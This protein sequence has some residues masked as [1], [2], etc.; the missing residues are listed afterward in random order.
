VPRYL[1]EAVAVTISRKN[2]CRYCVDAHSIML[3][4]GGN[5]ALAQAASHFP[6]PIGDDRARAVVDW[7]AA[8]YSPSAA[9]LRAPPF[10]PAETPE[11]IGTAVF[12]H[13]INR[14]VTVLLGVTPLPLKSEPFRSPL[15]RVAGWF[16]SGA[17]KRPKL[18]GESLEF[19][20]E[21]T[22]P[23]DLAWAA[24]SPAVAGAFAR[25]S[26]VINELGASALSAAV[27]ARVSERLAAWQG[28]P[29]GLTEGWNVR[30]GLDAH[31]QAALQLALTTAL[32]PSRVLPGIIYA[33][34]E[35]ETTDEKLLGVLAW[36]S[37]TAARRIGQWLFNPNQE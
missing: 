20:P 22:L 6:Q 14:M 28:E 21:V 10:T 17:V 32:M 27:R 29:A 16:F 36:A 11:L 3:E 25:L 9:I 18:A 8:T 4:A 30:A 23:A 12:Y 19:L 34:R 31:E 35:R 37:F 2:E 7:A 15:Q 13:Y 5:H 24:A 1:K 26:A 33:F